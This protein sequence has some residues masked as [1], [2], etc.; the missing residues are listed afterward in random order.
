MSFELTTENFEKEVLQE[1]MPV[2]VDFWAT[3]CM[4]CKMLAP[5]IDAIAS[6]YA[7]KAKIAKLDVDQHKEIASKY[8]IMSIPT[9][10]IFNNGEIVEQFTAVQPK[11]TYTGALDKILK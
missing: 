11:T 5:T 10:V 6:E 7:G 3:W 9:V 4:P 2:L 8:G 1:S